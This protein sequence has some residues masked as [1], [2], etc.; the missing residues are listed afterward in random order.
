MN[1]SCFLRLFDQPMEH[2]TPLSGQ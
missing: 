1:P 2:W